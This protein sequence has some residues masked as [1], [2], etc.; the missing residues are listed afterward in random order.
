MKIITDSRCLDYVSPGHAEAPQRV[1]ACLEKLRSQGSLPIEWGAPVLP[2]R[3]QLLRG[4]SATQLQRLGVAEDFDEDTPALPRISTHA[5]RSVGG[6]LAALQSALTGETAF[7]LMRPPGHHATP[8]QSMGFCYLNNVALGVLEAAQVKSRRIA[9]LDF[10]AHHGNGTEAILHGHPQCWL[11]SIH[12]HPAY[13]GTGLHHRGNCRNYPMKPGT[14]REEYRVALAGIIEDIRALKPDFLAVSAG[15]D[16]YRGDP[17]AEQCLEIDD[18]H[19]LGGLIRELRVPTFH[20]LEG[21]YSAE[22][23]ELVL[24]YLTGLAGR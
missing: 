4:H 24:A 12:Q 17:Q 7:S 5:R 14:P 16:A 23:P 20:A 18:Y 6:M 21:G 2:N 22:L 3:R 13:P 10:D 1:S 8:D 15:F 11:F 9:V 19:W